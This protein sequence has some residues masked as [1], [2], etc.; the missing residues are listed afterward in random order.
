MK[1]FHF[2]KEP[3]GVGILTID[4]PGERINKLSRALFA[5]VSELI[6]QFEAD[7]EL[8][9]IVLISGKEDNFI[10]G[11][12]IDDF[13]AFQNLE[14]AQAMSRLGQAIL[15]RLESLRVPVVAAIHG[16][17]LGGGLETA[18]A[19]HYRIAS[20]SRRTVLGQPEVQLGI[21]PGGGGTQRLPRLIGL[22]HALDLILSGRRVR[23]RAARRLGLVDDVVPRESLGVA[24]RR[25]VRDLAARR[26]IPRR[27]GIRRVSDLLRAKNWRW[28]LEARNPV[29]RAFIFRA[30]KR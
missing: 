1:T 19:C 15:A 29:G 6:E 10:A 9:G 13:L 7:S 18:L 26:I 28:I 30:A 24:A 12:D 5:E 4:A 14:D 3:D 11:A 22:T 21:L 25:A 23:S 16:A 2:A 17:C 20:D 27:V 8:K